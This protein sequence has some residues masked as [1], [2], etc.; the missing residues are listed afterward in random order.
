MQGHTQES[1]NLKI[2]S[3]RRPMTRRWQQ[4]GL[5][6]WGSPSASSQK[7]GTN[8]SMSGRGPCREG[9]IIRST[10]LWFLLRLRPDC[11]LDLAS[12]LCVPQSSVSPAGTA[13]TDYP[14]HP[15][16]AYPWSSTPTT[17][18]S[19]S[20]LRPKRG[21]PDPTLTVC[22]GPA[23]GWAPESGRVK[24]RCVQEKEKPLLR[25]GKC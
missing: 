4:K 25:Q 7:H 19:S 1:G 22:N 2:Q 12:H 16:L 14:W 5:S 18:P 17:F 3:S 24:P 10:W 9:E 8:P 23:L 13:G 20:I 15:A 6:K 21:F 11:P